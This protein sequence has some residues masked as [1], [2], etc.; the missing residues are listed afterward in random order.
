MQHAL[1]LAIAALMLAGIARAEPGPAAKPAAMD[2]CPP[3]PPPGVRFVPCSEVAGVVDEELARIPS[4]EGRALLLSCRGVQRLDR[5]D[6]DALACFERSSQLRPHALTLSNIAVLQLQLERYTQARAAAEHALAR[7]AQTGELCMEAADGPRCNE[8]AKLRSLIKLASD[9]QVQLQVLLDPADA[10]VTVDG[11]PLVRVGGEV[12]RRFT[13]GPAATPAAPSTP[14]ARFILELDPGPHSFNVESKGFRQGHVDRPFPVG[15]RSEL[16]LSLKRM[17]AMLSIQADRPNAIVQIDHI[18]VGATPANVP[19]PAG[20]YTVVV[21]KP[22]FERY[23]T[24]VR[25]GGGETL[26]M[27][28]RLVEEPPPVT[29][30]WWFWTSIGAF[31]ASSAIIYYVAQPAPEPPAYDG[32]STRWVVTP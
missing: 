14:G 17:P 11:R 5:D 20:D 23:E 24:R 16:D 18:D 9:R 30:T 32:G 22:G 31:L 26:T 6:I 1:K 27:T 29:K 15:A 2:A 7:D 21:L 3:E 13:T 28:A 10:R 12:S 8:Q 25:V 4:A 19:R